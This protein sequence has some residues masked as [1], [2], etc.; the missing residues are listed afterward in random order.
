M[1]RDDHEYFIERIP[2]IRTLIRDAFTDVTLRRFCQ[3]R[4]VFRPLQFADN[5]N[6]DDMADALIDHCHTQVLFTELL[7]GIEQ[8]NERQYQ[9]HYEAIYGARRI[10]PRTGQPARLQPLLLGPLPG[11]VNRKKELA[12]FHQML[13]GETP[14]RL[15][16]ILDDGERGK[17]WLL[18][19]ILHDCRQQGTPAILLDFD[20]RRSSGLAG[21]QGI[22]REVR[23]Y[24]GQARTPALIACEEEIACG[25]LELTGPA[26]EAALGRALVTDLATVGRAVLL[27][28][29]FEKACPAHPWLERWL[30]DRLP[31]ELPQALVVVA[32]RPE[33]E[34]R[35]FFQRPTP[36]SHLVAALDRLTDLGDDD[37]LTHWRLRGLDVSPSETGLLQIA[38]LSPAKMAFVGDLLEQVQQG[39]GR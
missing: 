4:P 3:D 34:C 24:L 25:R 35:R 37:I 29:T 19:H 23:R 26:C 28:D 13:A 2:A 8:V 36:W 10:E 31:G 12:L 20:D 21:C 22:A 17:T 32:G 9:R 27:V 14:R 18:W 11:W 6:L 1:P 16:R 38:R 39:G 5:A 30:F 7:A 33:P 15:L